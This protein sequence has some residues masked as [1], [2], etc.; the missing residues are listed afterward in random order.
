M[1]WAELTQADRASRGTK[2]DWK[3]RQAAGNSPKPLKFAERLFCVRHSAENFET[4]SHYFV[5]SG[6]ATSMPQPRCFIAP[7]RFVRSM[8]FVIQQRHQEQHPGIGMARETTCVE[9]LRPRLRSCNS[10]YPPYMTVERAIQEYII[11]PNAG[12]SHNRRRR[13]RLRFFEQL[14]SVLRRKVHCFFHECSLLS[15]V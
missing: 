14:G 13:F 4:L 5:R 2:L 6:P 12:Q 7:G 10:A 9:T 3:R 11:Q 1:A 8:E 15:V